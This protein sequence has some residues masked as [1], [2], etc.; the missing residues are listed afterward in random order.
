MLCRFGSQGT[1][2]GQ[3]GQYAS[4][5]CFT[6]DGAH[7][8]V[9]EHDN[10]RLSL[11]TAEGVFL[12]HIGSGTVSDGDKDVSFGVDGEI[13]VTDGRNNRICV[14]SSSGDKLLTTWRSR[15]TSDF[16]FQSPTALAV[17]GP[18]L[19]VLSRGLDVFAY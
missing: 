17:S 5:I 6:L 18:Y 19:Y 14:F 16:Q 13:L 12:K 10:S 1:G 8:L 3:I 4:G 9:A 7:L 2:P 15:A 11:F